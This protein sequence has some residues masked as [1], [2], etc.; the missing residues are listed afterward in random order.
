M[1]VPHRPGQRARRFAQVH[2]TF[3]TAPALRL[4]LQ[5]FSLEVAPR[6]LPLTYEALVKLAWVPIA[7]HCLGKRVR[8]CLAGPIPIRQVEVKVVAAKVRLYESEAV[9]DLFAARVH[10]PHSEREPWNG[11]S[12][13]TKAVLRH[14]STL[15]GT[16]ALGQDASGTATASLARRERSADP[17]LSGRRT[18]SGSFAR[19]RGR[20]WSRIDDLRGVEA[21]LAVPDVATND[22]ATL[23]DVRQRPRQVDPPAVLQ[24]HVHARILALALAHRSALL[25]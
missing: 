8:D 6:L 24:L 7:M 14:V 15:S 18:C 1:T 25:G 17:L 11:A 4:A 9:K 19:P 23:R 5:G 10:R 12:A 3:G 22:D 16:S 20:P 2:A 13:S 21:V